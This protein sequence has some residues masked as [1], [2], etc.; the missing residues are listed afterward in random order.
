MLLGRNQVE[1][2][3]I[4]ASIIDILSQLQAVEVIRNVV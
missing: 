3:K 4:T 2:E 1:T